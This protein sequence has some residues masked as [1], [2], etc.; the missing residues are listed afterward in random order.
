MRCFDKLEG[1]LLT[2]EAYVWRGSSLVMRDDAS[3]PLPIVWEMGED[4]DEGTKSLALTLYFGVEIFKDAAIQS[5]SNFLFTICVIF[6]S[7]ERNCN[8]TPPLKN[9]NLTTTYLNNGAYLLLQ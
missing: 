7:G 5:L 6:Y 1:G 3:S 8:G 2:T 4:G 9:S